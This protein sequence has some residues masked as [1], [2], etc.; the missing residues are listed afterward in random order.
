L[1]TQA[2]VPQEQATAQAQ[3]NQK[4]SPVITPANPRV[5]QTQN[6]RANPRATTQL[7][8]QSEQTVKA[9]A[10]STSPVK[11]QAAAET[12][13]TAQTQNNLPQM[14]AVKTNPPQEQ[15][16][17]RAQAANELAQA[18]VQ[19]DP[20]AAPAG[21][22]KANPLATSQQRVQSA[23]TAKATAQTPS[24]VKAQTIAEPVQIAQT[25]ANLPQLQ[26]AEAQVTQEK[27]EAGQAD[28]NTL[29]QANPQPNAQATPPQYARAVPQATSQQHV[30]AAPAA[31]VA[32][33]QT[34]NP[35]KA[36]A[37]V[38]SVQ[39]AQV[40]S[41]LPRAQAVQAKPQPEQATAQVDA[42]QRLAA[43][44]GS[45]PPQAVTPSQAPTKG[46]LTTA[47]E[48][49]MSVPVNATAA[50]QQRKISVAREAD[51][52]LAVAT[53]SPDLVPA[54]KPSVA[55]VKLES[56][57]SGSQAN[58]QLTAAK[59]RAVKAAVPESQSQG[60]P[61]IPA[62]MTP[63]LKVPKQVAKA[64]V[65]DAAPALVTAPAGTLNT[66]QSS[67]S[68]AATPVLAANPATLEQA[69]PKFKAGPGRA[70]P[71]KTTLMQ[72]TQGRP[73][74]VAT[75]RA[76]TTTPAVN[77]AARNVEVEAQARPV[78]AQP[79]SAQV[80][81]A[82]VK[83][84]ASNIRVADLKAL[85]LETIVPTVAASK[86]LGGAEPKQ[87]LAPAKLSS[88]Q[89]KAQ[90]QG[91]P[92][93]A[94]IRLNQ[95]W[96]PNLKPAPAL[97][98]VPSSRLTN[99]KAATPGIS[100]ADLAPVKV[101]SFDQKSAASRVA[102]K[103]LKAARGGLN[104]QASANPAPATGAGPVATQQ[105]V[106]SKTLPKLG[107]LQLAALP[108]LELNA[109]PLALP[110][111]GLDVVLPA[112]QIN[113]GVVLE[114]PEQALNP[115]FL[116]ENPKL[117]LDYIERLGGSEE[118]EK[119]VRRALDW[120]TR[121]QEKDG[122]WNR[123]GG[124]DVAATGMAMLA[125][126][127]WGAKHIDDSGPYQKQLAKAMEWMLREEKNKN[128]DLRG[129]HP[130]DMYDHGIAAIAM[131]EAYALT[132]DPDLKPVVERIVKFT[133]H[134]QNPKTGGWRYKPYSKSYT[135]KGD[136]SVT[137]WQIMALKSAAM[138]GIKVPQVAFQRA[139]RY[140]KQLRGRVGY[141]YQGVGP[142]PAM[143]AEGLFSQQLLGLSV[144]Q[145]RMGES[146]KYLQRK[147]PR[148][149]DVNYYYWYYGS[150]AMHQN[151]GEP[152]E[153]WNQAIRPIL[154]RNQ[155]RIGQRED[156]SWDPVGK[157]GRESGRCVTTAMATLS[158]EVYYR[159]LPLSSP[160]WLRGGGLNGKTGGGD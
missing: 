124:H 34:P 58:P 28:G 105:A 67:P 12:V 151:Q 40:K 2:E 155:V 146:V 13:Q 115:L 158:L 14:Q 51:V 116:R 123:P 102:E 53:A 54:S 117:R 68:Q 138:G 46:P 82:Q 43:A 112:M 42:S 153:K 114:V 152:W 56:A 32:S 24:P 86:Q 89:S 4:P 30:Q 57:Q 36:Q 136:M 76:K 100:T 107:A 66:A 97:G 20:R 15:G 99:A 73:A 125:Y 37:Q 78:S 8:I 119:A 104:F 93:V 1:A 141:G 140:L 147:L 7:K 128:G 95:I 84:Q 90:R 41:N 137:G 71:P 83:F 75:S 70:A 27:S 145:P 122:H 79:Q 44:K 156:G 98:T 35:V 77:A 132:K 25:Q 101:D 47:F 74:E 62:A 31:K 142:S 129:P 23:Q 81:A 63:A 135:N 60:Q 149:K 118:T 92:M 45:Q 96:K 49:V 3:A 110:G 91:M 21:N 85:E 22:A 154:L 5:A 11:A 87:T 94:A 160:E 72:A 61:D 103:S 17:A 120:F 38:E 113:P 88:V 133:V 65:T 18:N 144:A 55:R 16:T 59:S 48:A 127:G 130:G 9:T 26:V 19:A 148:R 157:W 143:T 52:Q 111:A 121:N 50:V 150:L 134:A 131:A 64:T 10:Q 69:Q 109:E 126:M 33:A 6:A 80:S 139:D 106:Q 39:T 29:A 159:Y 108:T